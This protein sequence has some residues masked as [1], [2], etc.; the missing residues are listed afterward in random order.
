MT[1]PAIFVSEKRD[2]PVHGRPQSPASL[3][4]YEKKQVRDCAARFFSPLLQ[5]ACFPYSTGFICQIFSAYSFMLRS[6][7]K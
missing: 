6:E 3:S 2:P 7:A 4:F 5:K 1:F